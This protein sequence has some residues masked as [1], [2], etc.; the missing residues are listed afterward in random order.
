MAQSLYRTCRFEV[1]ID[2]LRRRRRTTDDNDDN[3][4]TT[5]YPIISLGTL[6]S[7]KLKGP[8]SQNNVREADYTNIVSQNV[9]NTHTDGQKAK[10][11]TGVI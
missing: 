7:G 5:A 9:T 4:Q 11:D 10:A 3:R 6:G 2:D 1:F 8:I